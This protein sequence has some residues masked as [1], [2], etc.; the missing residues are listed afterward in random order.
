MKKRD[1][2]RGVFVSTASLASLAMGFAATS[3]RS[4]S[5]AS[6]AESGS[7][8]ASAS[9]AASAL[10]PAGA[11]RREPP[12]EM[13][14]K[15]TIPTEKSPV[16]KLEEWQHAK[17]VEVVRRGIGT[18]SCVVLL[19]REWLKIKCDT[20]VGAIH[21]HS[22]NLEGVAFWV[23]PKPELWTD[24]ETLNGG[25]MIFPLRRGDRRLLQ[26]FALRHD[27]CVGIGFDPGVMVDETWLEGD[28]A[29][30]VVMQ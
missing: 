8:S 5:A 30:I 25:E 2:L 9:I 11:P 3:L 10:A 24:M 14:E 19:V 20:S 1:L 27:P 29:P 26:F 17:R 28:P 7:A 18:S 16:P 13:L 4:A 6:P 15:L 12:I 22:G 23:H 21:Q